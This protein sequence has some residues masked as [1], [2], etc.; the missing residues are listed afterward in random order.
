MQAGHVCVALMAC[1]LS[2]QQEAHFK[3]VIV[4]LDGGEAGR[5]AAPEIAARLA[6]RLW[7]RIVALPDGKQ[8]DMLSAAEIEGLLGS[9]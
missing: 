9:V 8:P 2:E 5:N 4:M 6:R 7:V 3:Q 1:S